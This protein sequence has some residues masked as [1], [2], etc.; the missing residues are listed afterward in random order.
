MPAHS[1]SQ[2]PDAILSRS[3]SSTSSRN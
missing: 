2:L 3:P 1:R